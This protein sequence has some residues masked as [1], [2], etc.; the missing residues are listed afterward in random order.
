MSN[1]FPED[2]KEKIEQ[3]AGQIQDNVQQFIKESENWIANIRANIE[4][5]FPSNI[6]NRDEVINTVSDSLIDVINKLRTIFT[7]K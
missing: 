7:S 4:K 3:F 1:Q 5:Q 2:F 6:P